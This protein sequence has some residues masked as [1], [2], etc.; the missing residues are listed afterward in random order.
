[1]YINQFHTTFFDALTSIWSTPT[2]IG[3]D[4]HGQQSTVSII[5]HD[6]ST[7]TAAWIDRNG[8]TTSVYSSSFNSASGWGESQMLASYAG[9]AEGMVTR[10][11]VAHNYTGT[12][13][14][15]WDS[16]V[17]SSL[18]EHTIRISKQL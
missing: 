5:M 11:K 1:M 12:V 9:G 16:N 2:I 10:L 6:D 17:F 8:Q 3:S 14:V 4:T 7:A 15:I 18:Y 13:A